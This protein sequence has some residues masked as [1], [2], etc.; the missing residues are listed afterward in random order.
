MSDENKNLV[1]PDWDDREFED[2]DDNEPD[3]YD[4]YYCYGC[5]FSSVRDY[6][7]WGC[8]HCGAIMSGEYY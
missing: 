4:Y 7:G 1:E 3:E 8:P 6:G 5:F 2:D